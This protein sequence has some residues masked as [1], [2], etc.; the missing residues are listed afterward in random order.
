MRLIGTC[1]ALLNV[2]NMLLSIKLFMLVFRSSLTTSFCLSFVSA[3]DNH[4][5]ISL[6]PRLPPLQHATLEW[7]L[8]MRLA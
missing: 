2:Y 3:V 4:V 8:G 1:Y 6:V 7:G 5:S